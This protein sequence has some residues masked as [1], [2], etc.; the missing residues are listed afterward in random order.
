MIKI[1]SGY[2]P[3][4]L[5]IFAEGDLIPNRITPGQIKKTNRQQIYDYIYQQKDEIRRSC[6]FEDGDDFIRISKMP[7]HNITIGAALPYI[8]GF[9]DDIGPGT[10]KP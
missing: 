8:Q 6:P 7:S 9:L 1:H 4:D 5:F 3:D 2:P 10:K